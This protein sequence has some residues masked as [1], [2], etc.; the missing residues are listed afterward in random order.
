MAGWIEQRRKCRYHHWRLR[1]RLPVAEV[2]LQKGRACRLV[3]PQLVHLRTLL[4]YFGRGATCWAD[5]V[6][7]YLGDLRYIGTCVGTARH[8]LVLAFA[9][10]YLSD[11]PP[12]SARLR[13]VAI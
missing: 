8:L 7:S 5:P 13:F 9:D 11:T 10:G 6:R 3:L 1:Q 2:R 4:R 12:K